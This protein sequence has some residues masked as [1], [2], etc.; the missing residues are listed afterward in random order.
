M[1][2]QEVFDELY[3]LWSK[4]TGAGKC[5]WDSTMDEYGADITC[6]EPDGWEHSVAFGLYRHDAEFI[7][8]VHAA[9]PQLVRF[10]NAAVDEAARADHERD[11]RECRIAELELALAEELEHV[12][13]LSAELAWLNA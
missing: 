10:F 6:V 9:M 13:E 2:E 4:T 1:D 7:I 11:A 5:E 8:A 12:A 3:A